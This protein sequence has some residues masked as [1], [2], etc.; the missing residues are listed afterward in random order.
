MP[1]YDGFRSDED[2]SVAPTLPESAERHPEQTVRAVEMRSRVFALEYSKLL[3][4]S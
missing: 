1:A 2:K 4:Q 3:A